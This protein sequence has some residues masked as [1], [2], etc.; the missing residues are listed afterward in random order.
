MVEV[1]IAIL[2]LGFGMLGTAS[3]IM[4][5]M[6]S[7]NYSSSSS[8]ALSLARE[9]GEFMQ[10]NVTQTRVITGNVFLIDTNASSSLPSSTATTCQLSDCNSQDMARAQ[11]SDWVSR[12]NAQLPNGRAVVCRDTAPFSS[13]TPQWACNGSGTNYVMK[14]GWNARLGSGEEGGSGTYSVTA[15]PPKIVLTVYGGF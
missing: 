8:R 11:I 2:I 4:V 9:Y 3:L 10:G 12:F 7:S 14:I 5:S 6:K 13:G 1:L 15:T